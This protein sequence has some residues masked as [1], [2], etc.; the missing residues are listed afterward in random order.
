[1]RGIPCRYAA[2][3]AYITVM[4]VAAIGILSLTYRVAELKHAV[5]HLVEVAASNEALISECIKD[6]RND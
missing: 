3:F 2:L 1:M 4:I 5:D 6:K